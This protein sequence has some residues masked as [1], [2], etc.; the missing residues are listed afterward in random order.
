MS[1]QSLPDSRT[2]FLRT[3][4]IGWLLPAVLYL[5]FVA[6]SW[7]VLPDPVALHWNTAGSADGFASRVV[8][9]LVVPLGL[10]TLMWVLLTVVLARVPQ[11]IPGVRWG[12][13]VADGTTWFVVS[14]FA[15][16]L[17]GQR[18]MPS[19][20]TSSFSMW[21][22]L[23]ACAAA[24][25]G[26]WLTMRVLPAA[27]PVRR[28]GP[29]PADAPRLEVAGDS[30]VWW[31][32]T[33]RGGLGV[34]IGGAILLGGLV[35]SVV[36]APWYIALV[37]VAALVL[38][39][40]MTSFRVVIARQSIVARGLLGWPRLTVALDTINEADVVE[41]RALAWGGFGLRMRPD[42][43]GIITRGGPALQL[44]RP[45]ASQIVLTVDD[46]ET[47]AATVNTLLD[48]STT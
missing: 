26:G 28:S 38:L 25:V 22:V 47:A 23:S 5:A 17:V 30:Q 19:A 40:T 7:S 48:R 20:T 15:L 45:D 33:A 9:V 34:G 12:S 31:T 8:G 10:M 35:V 14:T 39:V 41:V 3:F 27:P 1:I 42:G 29:V 13:A 6:T 16:S 11:S 43:A 2:T 46:A 32:G 21:W 36:L 18:G 37:L 24:L 4:L 44:R